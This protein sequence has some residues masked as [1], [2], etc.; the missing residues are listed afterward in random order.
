MT[1]I[2]GIN[3]NMMTYAMDTIEG[4]ERMVKRANPETFL[5]HYDM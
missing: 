5:A 3:Q 1:I 4:D 2:V